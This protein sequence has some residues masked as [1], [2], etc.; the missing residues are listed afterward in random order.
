MAARNVPAPVPNPE[1]RKLVSTRTLGLWCEKK[2]SSTSAKTTMPRISKTTPVLLTMATSLTPK[3]FRRV[4]LMSTIAAIT[5]W[6]SAVFGTGMPRPFNSG[7][8]TI[9]TVTSTAVTVRTPA[10]R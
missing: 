9:G 8:R 2:I 10:K 5:T 3:M 1:P 6:A 4:V 7:I